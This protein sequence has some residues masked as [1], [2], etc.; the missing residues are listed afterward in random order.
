MIELY[1]FILGSCIGSFL[2]VCI[3][4][5]PRD[6]SVVRPRSFCPSCARLIRWYDNIPIVSFLLLKGRCRFCQ[7]MISFRYMMVEISTAF[8]AIGVYKW[9]SWRHWDG[10]QIALAMGIT[11]ALLVVSLIDL[12]YFI[13][14][15]EITYLGVILGVGLSILFPE[16]HMEKWPLWGLLKSLL[17]VFLGGG[18]LFLVGWLAKLMMKKEAMGLGD[19]KLMAMVGSFLGWKAALISI[20]IA[21]IVGSL[22]G[23]Y[24]VATKKLHFESRLPFGPF[25]SLGTFV[26][27]LW[28]DI[29]VRWYSGLIFDFTMPH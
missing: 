9:G 21:S 16:M 7:R 22:I 25:L 15:N 4:R 10:L 18:S 5:L 29:L 12:E 26:Y 19:V 24:F 27:L 8:L 2:N 23:V 11:F 3:Y 20:M 6:L 13:I 17:G 1:I 14:P 28:G